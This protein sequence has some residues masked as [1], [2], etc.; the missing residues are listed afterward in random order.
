MNTVVSII[1]PVFNGEMFLS[2]AIQSLIDQSFKEFELIVVD[3]GSTDNTKN[4]VENYINKDKRINYL[5]QNNSG[6]SKSRNK[7][8][9]LAKGKYV[10][11]LDSDDYYNNDFLEKMLYKITKDSADV[12][13]CGY[14]IVTS[15]FRKVKRTEFTDKNILEKYILGKVSIH[16]TGWMIERRVLTNN[17]IIFRVGVSW[18]EDIEFFCEVLAMAKKVVFVNE[19][20]TNYRVSF[21]DNRLSVF[22]IDKLDKDYESILRIRNNHNINSTKKIDDA[23]VLYRLSAL[24]TYRVM[25]AIRLGVDNQ[26][27]IDCFKKYK[28]I[29]MG[30][31]WNNGVRSIKLNIYKIMLYIKMIDKI[32]KDS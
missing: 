22:S 24:L 4:V 17:N 16:T 15:E 14:N 3:D 2:V 27:L 8:I 1:I 30:F 32:K 5:Y 12:C 13:Y 21:Y 7:G 18:G 23:L 19:Y 10:C 26:L 9:E 6:V 11:F 28:Y 20:L 25:E 31:S 29:L